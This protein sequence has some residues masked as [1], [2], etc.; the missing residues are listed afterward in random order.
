MKPKLQHAKNYSS[1]PFQLMESLFWIS[2]FPLTFMWIMYQRKSHITKQAWKLREKPLHP[3]SNMTKI[4]NKCAKLEQTA[5]SSRSFIS[6]E[7]QLLLLHDPVGHRWSWRSLRGSPP[8]WE[9]NSPWQQQFDVYN[10]LKKKSKMK[11]Q[12]SPPCLLSYHDWI[13]SSTDPGSCST[14]A[15]GLWPHGSGDK[16]E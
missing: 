1:L 7:V 13:Y 2:A 4:N 10:D 9:P 16:P 5:N 15:T 8:D 12:P 3:P 6:T 11:K 14:K